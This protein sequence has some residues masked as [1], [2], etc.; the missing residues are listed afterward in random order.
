MPGKITPIGDGLGYIVIYGAASTSHVTYQKALRCL[1]KHGLNDEYLNE[2]TARRAFG[3]SVKD[4]ERKDDNKLALDAKANL[5]GGIRLVAGSPAKI[6]YSRRQKPGELDFDFRRE[7]V[8]QLDHHRLIAVGK[9]KE[10]VQSRFSHHSNNLIGDDLRN[11]A[12]KAVEAMDGISLR[13]SENVR[14]TGGIYFVPRAHAKKLEA[15]AN[16][17][18]ELKIGYLKTFAVI[19]GRVEQESLFYSS[20]MQVASARANIEADLKHLKERVS[21]AE[22]AKRRL[23]DLKKLFLE[24]AEL[25]EMY[26][27]AKPLLTRIDETIATAE[28]KIA[29]LTAQREVRK[30][31]R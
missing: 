12:R 24:Y 13:G 17:L 30:R 10:F 25:T 14:D 1:L 20:M 28:A 9:D 18:D 2:P 4:T 7:T 22:K 29:E 16:V 21:S 31:A 11:M 27:A 3:R 15:L 19:R 26:S 8:T 6:I 23:E 5:V